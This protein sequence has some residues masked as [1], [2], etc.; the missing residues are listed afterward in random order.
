MARRQSHLIEFAWVPGADDMAAAVGVL[1]DLRNYLVDLIDGSAIGGAPIAPLRAVDAA[2]VAL[3]VGPLVPDGHSAFVEV[4]DVRI[5]AQKP[6][7]FVNDGFEMELFGREQ[8][9]SFPE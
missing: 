6:E 5:A 4:T 8:G 7:E 3:L 9:K 2:E 1:F